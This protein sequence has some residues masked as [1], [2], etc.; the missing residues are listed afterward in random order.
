MRFSGGTGCLLMLSLCTSCISSADVKRVADSLFQ[1]AAF[2]VLAVHYR[3]ANGSWPTGPH[4]VCAQ[5]D[6]T[7]EIDLR[8]FCDRVNLRDFCDRV[9]LTETARGLQVSEKTS[10][11][12][13]S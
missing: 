10:G 4:D 1:S 3:E 2:S 12:T 5:S 11:Q 6:A 13:R 9:K 7:S 8:D